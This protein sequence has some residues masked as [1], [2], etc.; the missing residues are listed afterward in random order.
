MDGPW[1]RSASGE[2]PC[3]HQGSACDFS[4][5]TSEF[6]A[7]T[8]MDSMQWFG[9]PILARDP[10]AVRMPGRLTGESLNRLRKPTFRL[11]LQSQEQSREQ[12]ISGTQDHRTDRLKTITAELSWRSSVQLSQWRGILRHSDFR[13]F[14]PLFC[15]SSQDAKHNDEMHYMEDVHAIFVALKDAGVKDTALLP[16]HSRER[17]ATSSTS[18]I[19]RL[20]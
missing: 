17:N 9:V 6:G 13:C 16:R 2:Q 8:V 15:R 5:D 14:N 18:C 19:Q 11:G 20:R 1:Y 3:S 7:Y 10:A 12:H 4:Q